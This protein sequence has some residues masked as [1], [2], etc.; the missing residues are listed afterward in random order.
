MIPGV[1]NGSASVFNTGMD[2]EALQRVSEVR[3]MLASGQARAR[4][5]QLRLSQRDVAD[6]IGVAP[7]SVHRWE[8]GDRLPRTELALKLADALGVSVT[9]SRTPEK[10]A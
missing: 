1:V 3:R 10:A 4:R 6:A 7:G 5:K 8:A 2:I 9:N